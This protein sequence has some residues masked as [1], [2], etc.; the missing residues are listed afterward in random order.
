MSISKEMTQMKGT[1]HTAWWSRHE[2]PRVISPANSRAHSAI[3]AEMQL[4][5][6]MNQAD[7]KRKRRKGT[8]EHSDLV[9]GLYDKAT[10]DWSIFPATSSSPSSP[11]VADVGALGGSS[12]ITW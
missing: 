7:H 10:N 9:T 12:V 3:E 1:K 4:A 8:T 11:S 6:D 2:W 5:M